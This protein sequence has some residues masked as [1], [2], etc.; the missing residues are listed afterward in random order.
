M[1]KLYELSNAY[2]M[3]Q[4]TDELTE[5]E[6]ETA[7][8]NIKEVFRDKALNIGKLVL[9]L[10]SDEDA[11][12][13]EI[14]RLSDRKQA[15]SNRTERIKSYLAQEMEVTNEDKIKDEVITISL[16]NNPPSVQVVNEEAIPANYWRTIPE[17]KEIDKRSILDEY[18]ES[19][20]IV[21]GV[22]IITDK[23]HIL[24]R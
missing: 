1:T 14:K 15:V 10:K 24:I 5:E 12:S 8:G 23:K 17:T 6:L 4:D 11:I 3:L 9:S 18:K 21:H 2:K 22:N 7:L 19:G 16:V 13:S 20:G